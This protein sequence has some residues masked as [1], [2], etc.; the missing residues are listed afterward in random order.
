MQLSMFS[1][2]ALR[3]LV[4]LANSP[5]TLLSTRQIADIHNAKFNHLSKVTTWLVTNGYVESSRGRGGGLRLAILPEEINL[6]K[7]LRQLEAD[8]PLVECFNSATNTCQLVP[9]CG[10]M[11]ALKDAQEAFFQALDHTTIANVMS[12]TP[13]M[14]KLIQTLNL[15]TQKP[16]E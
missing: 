14:S 1:D 4:H 9:A 12:G 11:F 7:L 8:K 13:N 2:Y 3:V 6:G 5:E 16:V 10:L 15:T